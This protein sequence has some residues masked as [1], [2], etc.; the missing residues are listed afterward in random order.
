MQDIIILDSVEKLEIKF[1]VVFYQFEWM[2]YIDKTK[3]ISINPTN[4]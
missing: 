3:L 2:S 4:Q 1:V